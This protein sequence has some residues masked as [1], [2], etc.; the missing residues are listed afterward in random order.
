MFF[1]GDVV[2]RCASQHIIESKS[3]ECNPVKSPAPPKKTKIIK[4]NNSNNNIII[5]EKCAYVVVVV[6]PAAV[7][8]SVK[9]CELEMCCCWMNS[10]VLY[11]K[12][13]GTFSIPLPQVKQSL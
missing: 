5:I 11:S 1:K 12:L 10:Y 13:N 8:G 7:V 2:E 4:N 3:F 6:I 9:A